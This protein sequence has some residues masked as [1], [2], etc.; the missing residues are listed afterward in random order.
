MAADRGNSWI[1]PHPPTHGYRH[2]HTSK[3]TSEIKWTQCMTERKRIQRGLV[4]VCMYVWETERGKGLSLYLHVNSQNVTVRRCR[5]D[6]WHSRIAWAC[7]SSI[8]GEEGGWWS[9]RSHLFASQSWW[10]LILP[11]PVLS[12]TLTVFI[13][14]LNLSLT[15][16]PSVC[17][18]LHLSLLFLS[19]PITTLCHSF[20]LSL[21]QSLAY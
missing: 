17:K 9:Q 10:L 5:D 6:R 3:Y 15:M 1:L 18:T 4:C 8:I 21:T 19:P 2:T 14:I 16:Q 20:T 12:F 13:Q 7:L 11:S